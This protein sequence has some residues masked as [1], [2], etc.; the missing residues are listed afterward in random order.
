MVIFPEIQL[1]RGPDGK[2][3]KLM[4]GHTHQVYDLLIEALTDLLDDNRVPGATDAQIACMA[5]NAILEELRRR[6]S[7]MTI[8]EELEEMKREIART[9][10]YSKARGKL[11]AP[12]LG[13]V[14]RAYRELPAD[15][16]DAVRREILEV[17]RSE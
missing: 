1:V 12:A 13:L 7:R 10:L 4:R 9:E 17:L 15:E 2:A 14:E 11:S 8:H 3:I 16:A 5:H 6:K